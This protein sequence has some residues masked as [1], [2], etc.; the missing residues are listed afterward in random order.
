[1]NRQAVLSSVLTIAVMLIPGQLGAETPAAPAAKPDAAALLA[2]YEDP[3]L[4]PGVAID[5]L[6]LRIG[7]M[8][9]R[10]ASGS[11]APVRV[12]GE[13]AGFF[14][15]GHGTFEYVSEETAEHPVLELITDKS[16]KLELEDGNTEGSKDGAKK[17]LG[18][19]V[20]RIFVLASGAPL[21][22]LVGKREALEPAEVSSLEKAWE[23]HRERFVAA[24]D[25]P[26]SHRFVQARIDAPD[27]PLIRA[28][29]ATGKDDLVFLFDRVAEDAEILS[30]LVEQPMWL[31]KKRLWPQVLSKQGLGRDLRAFHEPL[32]L[33]TDLTYT[34]IAPKKGDAELQIRETLS[35]V[36][37]SQRVF[38][39]SLY[40]FRYD[41]F[42]REYP[43]RL[44]AVTDKAGKALVYDHRDDELVV[45]LPEPAPAN[46]PLE[47][48]YTV[49]GDFLIRPRGDTHWRLGVGPWF[50]QP[51]LSGQYYTVH[52]TLETEDP[53]V[54]FAPGTTLQRK[55]EDGWHV[56]ENRIDKP[57]QFTVAQAGRYFYQEETQDGLTIRVASYG[58]KNL[59]GMKK[60]L[61]LSHKMIDFYEPWLGEF[62]FTEYNILEINELGWGQA[63]PAT[64]Y[65][66]QEAFT[67]QEN[68]GWTMGINHRFA[69]EIAHQYW[70]HVVK[71]GSYEEQWI[72][73]SFAEFSSCLV[74]RQMKGKSG[75][76]AMV[77]GWQAN[78]K[79]SH[80][81]APIPLANRLMGVTRD[82]FFHR[83]NLVYDKGAFLLAKLH[84][85][86]GE[87]KFL[88]FL[89]AYQKGLAWK[90]GTTQEMVTLLQALTGED[91][92]GF[93]EEYFWGTAMPELGG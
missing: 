14:F 49:R 50:P 10:L 86:I 11:A 54:P 43:F 52:S 76:K 7:H 41:E 51:A 63:P 5:E 78:A 40:S 24:Y 18:G 32:Y 55:E 29:I 74:M 57:V 25:T 64:M 42:G 87:E 28:E 68:R 15:Q 30:C 16:T 66:T 6:K 35:P 84:E 56:V 34:L 13:T 22:K 37:R 83:S 46:Q 26:P 72:T 61:K 70:G 71:M 62:P 67:P 73:E 23:A 17:V 9:L 82:A 48:R 4:G 27:K 12:A 79:M 1:M 69:H 21:P 33:L 90:F 77:G 47:L 53:F 89:N 3:S 91:Y 45:S 80:D 92:S 81:W 8:D 19:P 59:H 60:L 85:E 39:F 58:G 38:R 75:Y 31:P 65:I 2:A 36:R 44:E 88:A 93:F 20:Q